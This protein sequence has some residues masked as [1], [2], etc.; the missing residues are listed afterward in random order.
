MGK[1]WHNEV[2]SSYKMRPGVWLD[3]PFDIQEQLCL[4]LGWRKC[5]P[6]H[7]QIG[8]PLPGEEGM[9]APEYCSP[10]SLWDP[11][12]QCATQQCPQ[13]HQSLS[14]S[15]ARRE[16]GR[17][18]IIRDGTPLSFCLFGHFMSS[19][20]QDGSCHLPLNDIHPCQ[21]YQ[22]FSLGSRHLV[23]LFPLSGETDPRSWKWKSFCV[24]NVGHKLSSVTLQKGC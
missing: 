5:A 6:G 20:R 4:C 7:F 3:I 18:L 10:P 15:S 1:P 12:Y 9:E 24:W 14:I 16:P 23:I 2:V 17:I 19:K 11:P 22:M 21:P 8:P 13:H